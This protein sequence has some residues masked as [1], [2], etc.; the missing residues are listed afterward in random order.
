MSVPLSRI[1]LVSLLLLAAALPGC[2]VVPVAPD[3]RPLALIPAGVST[4]SRPTAPAA[5]V[6]L[7]A[8]LYPTNDVASRSGVVLGQIM[9]HLNGR[10]EFQFNYQGETIAGEATR[11]QGDARR[12]MASAYGS[13][14]T[15]MSCEYQMNGPALG[16]GTCSFSD[17]AKY[18]LHIG[19]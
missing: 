12:G 19:G 8:R 3:G 18:D 5:P 16:S 14:G 9:N 1:G 17:G 15:Y 4:G 10:G 6:V 13:R 2:F 7:S 11:A